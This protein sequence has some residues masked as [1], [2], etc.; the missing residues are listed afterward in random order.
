MSDEI[1][2]DL[3]TPSAAAV[4]TDRQIRCSPAAS[5]TAGRESRENGFVR[6]ECDLTGMK[7]S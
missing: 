3:Q 5:T 1:V 7:I 4:V 2:H 6:I